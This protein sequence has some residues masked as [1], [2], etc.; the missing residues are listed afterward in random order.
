MMEELWEMNLPNAAGDFVAGHADMYSE[1]NGETTIYN[2]LHQRVLEP[3]VSVTGQSAGLNHWSEHF[4][5]DWESY[6]V[7]KDDE[8]QYHIEPGSGIIKGTVVVPHYNKH[9]EMWKGHTVSREDSFDDF[10]E[11]RRDLK[12]LGIA[13]DDNAA[14]EITAG[15][16]VRVLRGD[17]AKANEGE[18]WKNRRKVFTVDYRNG[19]LRKQEVEPTIVPFP[20][21]DLVK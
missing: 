2:L 13:V 16:L 18:E 1:Q 9:V 21:K 14:L 5:S 20:F 17:E 12:E 8:W 11:E 19:S 6:I 10:M 4:H 15:G 3:G 7:N